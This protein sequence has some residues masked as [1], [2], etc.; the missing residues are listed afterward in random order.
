MRPVGKEAGTML[1]RH[2][3]Y[4]SLVVALCVT[5]CSKSDTTP[6][7]NSGTGTGAVSEAS[8]PKVDPKTPDNCV[9]MF[10]EAVKKGDDKTSGALLTKTAREKT[11]EMNLQVAPP[12]SETATFEVGETELHKKEQEEGAYVTSKW[13]DLGD[14]GKP[15][16]DEII[17]MLVKDPDGWRIVGMGVKVFPDLDPVFL[18]FEDPQDMLH[19]QQMVE[20]EMIRR[21]NAAQPP[22][23]TPGAQTAAV[24]GSGAVPTNGQ[25][26]AQVPPGP[27]GS[28]SQAQLPQSGTPLQLK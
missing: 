6:A 24:P 26:P 15:H 3:W 7:G 22:Q 2:R 19:K 28:P 14:D 16:T 21:A 5:G 20:Q 17:W 23:G 18:N 25:I 1:V 11:G 4:L 13:T 9:K 8:L 27:A 10:L 12:G